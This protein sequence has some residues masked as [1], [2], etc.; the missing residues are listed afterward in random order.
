[1]YCTV[2]VF[3]CSVWISPVFPELGQPSATDG[4]SVTYFK[5]DMLQYLEAYKTRPL[6]E[7]RTIIK[8]YDLSDA[9]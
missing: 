7:W 3:V 5:R 1:M 2:C 4:D 6:E 9:K 8:G